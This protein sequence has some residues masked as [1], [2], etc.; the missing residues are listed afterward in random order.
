MYI[1]PHVHPT[2]KYSTNSLYKVKT[3]T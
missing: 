3:E 1:K 2:T